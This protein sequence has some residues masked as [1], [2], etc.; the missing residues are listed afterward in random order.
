MKCSVN[1]SKTRKD[2]SLM[3][4]HFLRTLRYFK[5]WAI[6]NVHAILTY[7]FIQNCPTGWGLHTKFEN[8]N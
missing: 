1:E 4:T 2:D 8:A 3:K 6:V 7:S 5:T